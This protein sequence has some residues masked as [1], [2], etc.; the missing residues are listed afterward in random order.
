MSN[1]PLYQ[2][3]AGLE[4]VYVDE[5]IAVANKA[6]GLLT[7]PGRGEDKAD[8]LQSR[9]TAALGLALVVHRLDMSTSG[10]VI[11]ARHS[12]AQSKLARAFQERKVEKQYDAIVEGI[13]TEDEGTVD[14]PLRCDWP[15]RPRQMVCYEW[16]KPAITRYK[17]VERGAKVTQVHLFPVTGR[18]HQLRVHMQ[19]IGHPILGDEL[20]GDPTLADSLCLHARSLRFDHP[21]TG[22][23]IALQCNRH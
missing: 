9:V 20:Y 14:L 3:P 8:C 11:F 6:S 13:V 4:L 22:E 17:V 23:S 7:V 2:P 10:L 16:G 12:D 1:S 18:S 15:N 5:H 21:A 19:A